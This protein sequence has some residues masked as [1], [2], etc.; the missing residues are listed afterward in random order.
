MGLASPLQ[1]LGE[2][3]RKSIK[4]RQLLPPFVPTRPNIRTQPIQL[5]QQRGRLCTEAGSIW[6][7]EIRTRCNASMSCR[8]WLLTAVNL[9]EG[10]VTTSQIASISRASFLL[11]FTYGR[12]KRGL[13]SL[14]SCFSCAISRAH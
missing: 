4:A 9:I 1:R 5:I 2:D 13:I 6:G 8:A 14:T 3:V 7:S 12:T 10:R 11:D